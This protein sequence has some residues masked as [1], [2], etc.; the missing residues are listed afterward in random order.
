MQVGQQLL[1]Q[2]D[3]RPEDLI[4]KA[5][6]SAVRLVDLTANCFPGFQDRTLYR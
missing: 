5:K 1:S 2:F 3:G 4:A 6:G